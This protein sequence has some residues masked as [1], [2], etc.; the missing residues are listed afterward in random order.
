MKR[1]RLNVDLK[2]VL[3]KVPVSGKQKVSSSGKGTKQ[4][5]GLQ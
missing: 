4:L 2:I 1:F 3:Q 5:L